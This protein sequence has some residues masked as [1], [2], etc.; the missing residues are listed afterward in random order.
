MVAFYNPV[1]YNQ[2][3]PAAKEAILQL[4]K[5]NHRLLTRNCSSEL[6]IATG[7]IQW[8]RIIEAWKSV[9][10]AL[11]DTSKFAENRKQRAMSKLVNMCKEFYYPNEWA[12]PWLLNKPF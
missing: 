3:S 6:D 5:I 8:D 4:D 10:W 9:L 7:M 12:T 2:P 1:K 11:E